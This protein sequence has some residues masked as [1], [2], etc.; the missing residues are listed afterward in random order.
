MLN[1][2]CSKLTSQS[3]TV[4]TYERTKKK[5]KKKTS[6]VEGRSSRSC[7][8]VCKIPEWKNLMHHMKKKNECMKQFITT[9]Y[10]LDGAQKYG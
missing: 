9:L 1:H 10:L 3:N 2:Q 6:Q 4:V 7:S 8:E 5:R